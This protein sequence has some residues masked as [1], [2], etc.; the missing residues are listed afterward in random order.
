M[1]VCR[2][3][4]L[5]LRL[6]ECFCSLMPAAATH[7]MGTALL[8][9]YCDVLQTEVRKSLVSFPGLTLFRHGVNT[10]PLTINEGEQ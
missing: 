8:A 6:K 1:H 5:Y 9:A 7:Y 3:A 2:R 10:L 4:F